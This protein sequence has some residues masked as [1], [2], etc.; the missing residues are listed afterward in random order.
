M[1]NVGILLVI[2]ICGE[3]VYVKRLD[4][5][6]P[7]SGQHCL[8]SAIALAIAFEREDLLSIGRKRTRIRLI[9]KKC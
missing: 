2:K 4:V 7:R 6:A 5:A 8:E 9:N 3:E 1:R